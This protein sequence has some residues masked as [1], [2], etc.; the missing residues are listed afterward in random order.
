MAFGNDE[1]D[2]IDDQ[3]VAEEN[4]ATTPAQASPVPPQAASGLPDSSE[5]D[6]IR[7]S[8]KDDIRKMEW[9]NAIANFLGASNQEKNNE[10]FSRMKQDSLNN[11]RLAEQS[12]DDKI[13]Q[14]MLGRQQKQFDR[15][16]Q[17]NDPNSE[18]SKGIRSSYAKMFPDMVGQFDPKSYEHL[19]AAD[20]KTHLSHAMEMKNTADTKKAI[21]EQNK[22]FKDSQIGDKAEARANR[23]QEHTDKQFIEFGNALA[24]T[25]GNPALAAEQKKLG[26]AIHAKTM[27]NKDP[28]SLS[29][30]EIAELAQSMAAQF[31]GGGQAA[32]ST[33]EHVTPQTA[34]KD[35]A[36]A[37]SYVTG[38]PVEANSPEFVKL[39]S[40]MLDRQI[41]TSQGIIADK[42]GIPAEAFSHL[43]K[44]DPI[45]C[46][47]IS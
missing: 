46:A 13:K 47:N 30:I 5:L 42:M 41:E 7:Q 16:D 6:A 20:I 1:E 43:Q 18:L 21:A 45:R 27:V 23:E 25:R 36:K 17:E 44:K 26:S 14:Y 11:V 8:S 39:F 22:L 24:N 28:S 10:A 9:A 40:H 32:I 31:S 29:P 15:Q 34:S 35:I 19:S 12:R 4:P 33:I 38:K 2:M 37:L 3:I